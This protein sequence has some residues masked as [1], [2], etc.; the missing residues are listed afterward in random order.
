MP[1]RVQHIH[2]AEWNER[3]AR[4]LAETG[5]SQSRF[6]DWEVTALFYS[7]LHYVDA[8]LDFTGGIHPTSHP[9]RNVLV[10]SR[11]TVAL[12]YLR[13]YN[14]SLDARYNVV[15][16][17]PAEVDKLISDDYNRIRDNI[18]RLLDLP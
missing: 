9:A 13:L 5:G 3:A 8:F 1:T 14:R 6:T 18:R 15:S 17:P 12:S 7:A 4:V 11:T 2:Q 10:A 16:I